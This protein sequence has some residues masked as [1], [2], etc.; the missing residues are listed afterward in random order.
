MGFAKALTK[1]IYTIWDDSEE[2]EEE[3]FQTV[4]LD[5]KHWIT[6]PVPDRPLCIHEHF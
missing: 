4:A 3:N 6:D 2:E 1:F 5:D